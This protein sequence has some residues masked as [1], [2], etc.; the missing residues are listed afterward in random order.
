MRFKRIVQTVD[1]H[2]VGMPTRTVVG[3]MLSI[4]GSTMEEKMLYQPLKSFTGK[5]D[6]GERSARLV[7]VLQQ[8]G[9]KVSDLHHLRVGDVLGVI[10]H[11]EQLPHIARPV[12]G[13]QKGEG[14][15]IN[16]GD[17]VDKLVGGGLQT[18]ADQL[19]QVLQVFPEGR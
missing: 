6:G 7:P 16:L 14:L 9:G 12:V 11:M 3:G 5:V 19:L 13:P 2:T 18:V 1:S 8:V 10:Q 17:G 4:P 15:R